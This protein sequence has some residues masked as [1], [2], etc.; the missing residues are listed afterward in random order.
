M[1]NMVF[2]QRWL[3]KFPRYKGRDLYIAGESYA[4]IYYNTAS[5]V[6]SLVFVRLWNRFL[7]CFDQDKKHAKASSVW[8]CDSGHYIPQLAEAMV[9]FNKKDRIFNLRGVAV[10]HLT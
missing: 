7:C 2:L 9:E 6:F 1:D 4:G 5:N 8:D 3:Q 10:S